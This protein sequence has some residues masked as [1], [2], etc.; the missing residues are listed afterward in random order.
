MRA[1]RKMKFTQRNYRSSMPTSTFL[2]DRSTPVRTITGSNYADLLAMQDGFVL[3]FPL[4]V[5]WPNGVYAYCVTSY[6][7]RRIYH[8]AKVYVENDPITGVKTHT[9]TVDSFWSLA[10]NGIRGS[11]RHVGSR[12]LQG[13][14]NAY[15]FRWNHR[16]DGASMFRAIVSRLPS[17]RSTPTKEPERETLPRNR[18]L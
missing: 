3:L 17:S 6:Q 12:Y 18:L 8:S 16:R 15:A 14:L 2:Y 13:Y 10:K 9:N 5:G 1:S 7:H 4:I 11:N